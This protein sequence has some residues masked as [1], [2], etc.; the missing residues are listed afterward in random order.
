M[1]H[2]YNNIPTWNMYD[3]TKEEHNL[4][5]QIDNFFQFCIVLLKLKHWK[6]QWI[7]FWKDIFTFLKERNCVLVYII[8]IN[9]T[10]SAFTLYENRKT[11]KNYLNWK[12]W[13]DFL[14]CKEKR[15]FIYNYY[16]IAIFSEI[17]KRTILN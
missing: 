15:I 3:S 1:Q 10:E 2:H 8:L 11:I 17:F 5:K 4:I 6:K 14:L 9:W 12:N 7:N 13:S 16:L